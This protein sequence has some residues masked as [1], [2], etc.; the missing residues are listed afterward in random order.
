MNDLKQYLI[1][2]YEV[3]RDDQVG[4]S[5]KYSTFF[6]KSED[7]DVSVLLDCFEDGELNEIQISLFDGNDRFTSRY[8]PQEMER[9]AKND[10]NLD[11]FFEIAISRVKEGFK[12]KFENDV[13]TRFGGRPKVIEATK[14]MGIDYVYC[15]ELGQW[16][17]DGYWNAR[18]KDTHTGI[19][20]RELAIAAKL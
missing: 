4:R 13:V 10:I 2:N 8:T 9:I 15:W 20:L 12:E 14:T 16:F 5:G 1:K 7:Y 19:T 6:K 17:T 18:L 3:M 11:Q